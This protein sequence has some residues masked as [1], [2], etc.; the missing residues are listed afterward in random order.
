MVPLCWPSTSEA[1][2]SPCH[3]P[4][5]PA[6]GSVQPG[7][8]SSG[9]TRPAIPRAPPGPTVMGG[10]TWLAS[11]AWALSMALLKAVESRRG[12][13]NDRLEV[14]AKLVWAAQCNAADRN[15]ARAVQPREIV[16]SFIGFHTDSH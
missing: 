11:S 4:T 3:Q 6:G 13:P 2:P 16:L 10:T 15:Q 9:S 14:L 7:R 1:L 12:P 5:S 8:L